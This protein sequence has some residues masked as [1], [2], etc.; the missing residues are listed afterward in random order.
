MLVMFFICSCRST[1]PPY[2][3]AVPG[4][5][6]YANLKNAFF[7]KNNAQP[8]TKESFLYTP[9]NL[10]SLFKIFEVDF[11]QVDV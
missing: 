8:P 7:W 5:G 10:N 3:V 1:I 9:H 4:K 2:G 11:S 6:E